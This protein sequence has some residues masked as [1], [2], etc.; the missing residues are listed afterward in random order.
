LQKYKEVTDKESIRPYPYPSTCYNFPAAGLVGSRL[1]DQP[2]ILQRLDAAQDRGSALLVATGAEHFFYEGLSL[3][4]THT[5][6]IIKRKIPTSAEVDLTI[7]PKRYLLIAL[8]NSS[9]LNPACR[10]APRSV[11]VARDA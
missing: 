4:F 10:M 5:V 3:S 11:P 8:T 7:T 1:P 9:T 2:C 6:E